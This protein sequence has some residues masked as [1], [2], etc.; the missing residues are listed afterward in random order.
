MKANNKTQGI[1]RICKQKKELSF[2]HIPPKSAFN[3][4]N[5]YYILSSTDFYQNF[6]KYNTEKPKSKIEQGGLGEYCLCK[7]CNNY[8]G[9]KYVREYKKF[10]QIAMSIINE[11]NDEAIKSFQ[12]DISDINLLKFLKQIISIFICSNDPTFTESY[13]ELLNF[14]KEPELEAL[15]ENYRIYMYLNKE[16]ITKNGKIHFT[17]IHGAVCEFVYPPFGFILNI[18]NPNRV[19]EATEITNFKLYNKFNKSEMK[20]IILNKYNLYYP[21]PLDFRQA[22]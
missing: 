14:I 15:P 22:K 13:P 8:L 1:C 6:E 12:F 11:Y 7:N 21:F 16:G 4:N 9:Q 19:M 17:N 5:R 18:N 2:E 10:A 3:K 20:P